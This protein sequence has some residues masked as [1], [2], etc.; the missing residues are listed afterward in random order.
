LALKFL[1]EA[2]LHRGAKRPSATA[3]KRGSRGNEEDKLRK[4]VVPTLLFAGLLGIGTYLALTLLPADD[5]KA[6]AIA[7]TFVGLGAAV[8]Y[9]WAAFN[10]GV[11]DRRKT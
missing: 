11:F 2:D 8:V 10:A 4:L 7:I 1:S 5:H 6:K 3:A 9:T